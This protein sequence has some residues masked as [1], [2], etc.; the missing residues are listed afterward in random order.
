MT[1]GRRIASAWC[2]LALIATALTG[3]RLAAAAQPVH[4]IQVVAS[5]FTFE[6]PDIYERLEAGKPVTFT[7]DGRTGTGAIAPVGAYA[8]RV[9]LPGRG[10]NMLWIAKRIH[11]GEPCPAHTRT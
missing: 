11:L 8:L 10:R 3:L 6:P 1:G 5:R 9:N 7:W 2:G 4:E